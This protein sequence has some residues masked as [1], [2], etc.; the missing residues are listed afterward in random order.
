MFQTNSIL[1]DFVRFLNFCNVPRMS[2][3]MCLYVQSLAQCVSNMV[4]MRSQPKSKHI[5]HVVKSWNLSNTCCK[6]VF[7]SSVMFLYGLICSTTRCRNY[8]A[9]AHNLHNVANP[10][11][12]CPNP[13]KFHSN[14]STPSNP[15]QANI[16]LCQSISVHAV[17]CHSRISVQYLISNR[18]AS[19]EI[20]SP[21]KVGPPLAPACI[22]LHVASAWPHTGN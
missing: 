13:S 12:V 18:P 9:I 1:I 17:H 7:N 4:R 6:Y 14:H 19:G 10:T 20:Q 11:F 16:C 15:I 21:Y 3:N 5:V 2:C 22:C 8:I